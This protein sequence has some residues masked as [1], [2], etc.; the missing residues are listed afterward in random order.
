MFRTTLATRGHGSLV[1]RAEILTRDYRNSGG[2]T[3]R[4]S[5]IVLSGS[6]LTNATH[7]GLVSGMVGGVV[8]E[9][10]LAAQ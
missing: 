7:M 3:H 4:Q 5:L 2:Y 1:E 8:G 6:L 9:W 10:Y